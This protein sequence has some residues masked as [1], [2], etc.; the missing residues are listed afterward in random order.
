MHEYTETFGVTLYTNFGESSINVGT[1]YGRSFLDAFAQNNCGNGTFFLVEKHQ[2]ERMDDGIMGS[3]W[4]GNEIHC[5]E[6]DAPR[7]IRML[8]KRPTVM[9]RKLVSWSRTAEHGTWGATVTE[10]I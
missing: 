3:C 7:V 2:M 9:K 4:E 10:D 5:S 1:L 8:H 6:E